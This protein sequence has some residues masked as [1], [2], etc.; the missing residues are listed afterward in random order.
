MQSCESPRIREGYQCQTSVNK[1]GGRLHFWSFC[2]NV[3]I[4]CPHSQFTYAVFLY[5]KP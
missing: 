1:W 4:E 2:D 5:S 3:T